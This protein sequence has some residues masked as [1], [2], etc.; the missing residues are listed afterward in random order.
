MFEF[1]IENKEW[2]FSGIGISALTIIFLIIRYIITN[3]NIRALQK[4]NLEKKQSNLSSTPPVSVPTHTGDEVEVISKNHA[5]ISSSEYSTH[6]TP[7]EILE[8]I[9]SLP[10]FQQSTAKENFIGIKF[11][12]IL[13]CLWFIRERIT[14]S[15]P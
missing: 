3:R 7:K 5:Q 9:D 2:L 12:G 11:V 4:T 13:P 1:I 6:P 14:I 15:F 8:S 10:P